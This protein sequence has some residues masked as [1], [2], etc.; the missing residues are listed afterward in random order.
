MPSVASSRVG[1]AT[2]A[3]ACR[4]VEQG[5]EATTLLEELG[6]TDCAILIDAAVSGGECGDVRRFDAARE[7]LPAAKFGMSTHGFG[8]AE[9]IELARTLGQLPARCIVFAIEAR[10][11]EL[12]APLSPEL[13]RAV[14]DGC[15][16]GGGRGGSMESR[17]CTST[18]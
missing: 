3:Q 5:G 16:P 11:F 7:A 18:G 4:L 8:L 14:D 1:C 2:F 6:D 13:V 17:R 15:G 10:S 12:G 9:A